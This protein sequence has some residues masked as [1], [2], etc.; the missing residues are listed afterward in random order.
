M[1]W[2]SNGTDKK[3][4]ERNLLWQTG[5]SHRPPTL[6]QRYV[7]LHAGW[8]RSGGSSKFSSFI[9]IGWT[10]F[11]MWGTNFAIS[12]WLGQWL[13]ITDCASRDLTVGNVARPTCKCSCQQTQPFHVHRHPQPT[14][15]QSY[16]VVRSLDVCCA[17]L[18]SNEL[19]TSTFAGHTDRLIMS[20]IY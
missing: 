13:I 5:C 1:L 19:L 3:G 10:V 4:E 6:T 20:I 15:S 17:S 18:L 9:K 16:G 14:D 2:Y 7:V 11:E 8:S 12:Y